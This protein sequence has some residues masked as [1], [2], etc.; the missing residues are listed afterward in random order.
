MF[1]GAVWLSNMHFSVI[2]AHVL[3]DHNTL[4]AVPGKLD[5]CGPTNV[6]MCVSD[7]R[8]AATATEVHE[9]VL[10][11]N[12][13]P[14]TH[15]H[16]SGASPA[17]HTPGGPA[18]KIHMWNGSVCSAIFCIIVYSTPTQTGPRPSFSSLFFSLLL[19]LSLRGYRLLAFFIFI[20]LYF[21]FLY[22][23]F[24]FLNRYTHSNLK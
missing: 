4:S 3:H 1:A 6:G 17:A 16:G 22:L 12:G 11:C 20:Y 19:S 14:W 24:I 13:T 10:L 18:R 21:Y 2:H 5:P 8:N 15:G 23:Q 7:V 9:C